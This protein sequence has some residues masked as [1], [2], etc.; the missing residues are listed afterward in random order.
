MGKN[1]KK[2]KSKSKSRA[3]KTRKVSAVSKAAK[4]EAKQQELDRLSEK[5]LDLVIG[6]KV[7]I[8]I[9]L[10]AVL[11]IL[12]A[13]VIVLKEFTIETVYVEGNEHY[14]SSQISQ[15]VE[16]GRF[17]DNSIYLSLKYSNKSITDIPFIEKMD[18]D[19]LDRNSIKVTVYEKNLAGYVEYLGSY[20]YFDKDGVVIESSSV[21]TQGIPLVTGLSFDHFVMY[22]PLP[23]ENKEIFQ[24]ILNLTQLLN[25][26]DI[27]TDGIHFDSNYKMTLYFDGVR[28]SIGDTRL[29]EEKV[30]QLGSILP[31]LEGK[32]GVLDMTTYDEDSRNVTFTT[33]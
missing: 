17:G 14:T 20:M 4:A 16:Q 2:K 3:H 6:K 7:R 26:Y 12:I 27:E 21:K 15:F 13:I 1:N 5:E 33:D 28:V 9:A 25:K 22:E 23:V 24:T 8:I 18:V 30:Q 19:V 11:T 10:S 31:Q 29:L 32:S